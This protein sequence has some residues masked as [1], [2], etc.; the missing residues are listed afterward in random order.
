MKYVVIEMLQNPEDFDDFGRDMCKTRCTLDGVVVNG[1]VY[2]QHPFDN[3]LI[4][5]GYEYAFTNAICKQ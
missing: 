4:T 2:I 5:V 1:V 3:R